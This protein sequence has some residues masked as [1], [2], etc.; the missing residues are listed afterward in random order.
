MFHAAAK[1]SRAA[2]A[3]IR[4]RTTTSVRERNSSEIHSRCNSAA[5]TGVFW[6]IE[7]CKIPDGLDAVDV[8]KNIKTALAEMGHGGPV[9]IKAYTNEKNQLQDHVFHSAGIELKRVSEGSKGKDRARDN[10]ILVGMWGWAIDRREESSTIM[11]I[12]DNIYTPTIE[13]LEQKNHNV[14]WRSL[15]AEGKPIA[16][17]RT[18]SNR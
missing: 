17:T 2:F 15:S 11:V 7:D 3:T 14:L 1:C 9:S 5:K 18:S 6:D 4:D 12:S 10:A 13:E 16:Q 8:S